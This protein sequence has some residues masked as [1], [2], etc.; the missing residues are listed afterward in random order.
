MRVWAEYA[1]WWLA[2]TAAYLLLVTSPT[3][4]EVPVGLLVGAAG[5]CA[6]FAGRR[7][8]RPPLHVPSWVRSAW[9]LPMDVLADAVTMTPLLLTGRALRADCG[10]IQEVPLPDDDATRAWAVLLTSAAPGSLATDVEER[11]DELVLQRHRLTDH[12][13]ATSRLGAR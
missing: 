6:G 12:D 1:V 8:F 9:L 13:R 2:L 5:A 3:G 4:L 7:A 10:D 11:G